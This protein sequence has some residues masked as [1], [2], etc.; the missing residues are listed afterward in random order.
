MVPRYP[1]DLPATAGLQRWPSSKLDHRPL[2][3]STP[4]SK[5][6][7]LS[8]IATGYT[9]CLSWLDRRGSNWE[10]TMNR[11]HFIAGLRGLGLMS[12][13]SISQATGPAKGPVIIEAQAG[14]STHPMQMSPGFPPRVFPSFRNGSEECCTNK[15][16]RRLFVPQLAVP[17]SYCWIKQVVLLPAEPETLQKSS[18]TDDPATRRTAT[19]WPQRHPGAP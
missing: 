13:A 5:K 17:T 10:M 16:R 14:E 19:L 11:R 12:K 18:V 2:P 4:H 8:H 3:S 15:V 1:P 6:T 9:Q 7:K